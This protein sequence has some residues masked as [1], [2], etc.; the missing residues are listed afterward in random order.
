MPKFITFFSYTGASAKAMIDRPSDRSAAARELV[1]SLGGQ[2]ESFYWMQGKHDGFFIY[3]L[4]DSVSA[5]GLS[6]AVASTG[7]IGGIQSH[8]IYD[9]DEQAAIVQAAKKATYKP[10]TG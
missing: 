8:Q 2:M 5:S 3:S 7:A 6:L 1:E 4:P 9:R 10:P